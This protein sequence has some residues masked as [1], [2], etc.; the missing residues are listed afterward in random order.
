MAEASGSRTWIVIDPRIPYAELT[1]AQQ[2]LAKQRLGE[3][4]EQLK[5]LLEKLW[6]CN[7]IGP[8]YGLK[9]FSVWRCLPVL[10]TIQKHHPKS[11]K[12]IF[13]P[14]QQLDWSSLSTTFSRSVDSIELFEAIKFSEDFFEVCIVHSTKHCFHAEKAQILKFADT[15]KMFVGRVSILISISLYLKWIKIEIMAYGSFPSV[16][17]C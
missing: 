5:L 10:S 16:H 6:T 4:K 12:C 3:L 8:R 7:L 15:L 1:L 13:M 17:A 2:D 9:R 14:R 11:L